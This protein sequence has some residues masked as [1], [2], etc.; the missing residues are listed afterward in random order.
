MNLNQKGKRQHNRYGER[1]PHETETMVVVVVKCRRRSVVKGV[2]RRS[3][4]N[5]YRERVVMFGISVF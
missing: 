3:I 4:Y 5:E 2:L 1:P